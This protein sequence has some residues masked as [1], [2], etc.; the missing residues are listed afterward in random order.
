MN[1]MNRQPLLLL[2]LAFI[3]IC[4]AVGA[5]PLPDLYS[6][7]DFG[8]KGDGKTDDTGAFQKALD[9]AAKREVA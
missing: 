9:A 7:L 2:V 1:K 3:T 4:A 5:A 8:A 6:V